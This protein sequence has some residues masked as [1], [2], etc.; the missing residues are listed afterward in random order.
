MDLDFQFLEA[1]E[2][3]QGLPR[4]LS[5]TVNTDLDSKLWWTRHSTDGL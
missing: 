4:T 1:F 5:T 2:S 3:Y